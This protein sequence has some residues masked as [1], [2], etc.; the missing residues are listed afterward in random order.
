MAE[1]VIT[2]GISTIMND[3]HIA[4]ILMRNFKTENKKKSNCLSFMLQ[5]PDFVKA[6]EAILELCVLKYTDRVKEVM[7]NEGADSD[8]IKKSVSE[9]EIKYAIAN[10][11]SAEDFAW[12]LMF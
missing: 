3:K 11:I 7:Q 2:K 4:Y 1:A 10:D 5:N 6:W 12:G 9:E 8:F